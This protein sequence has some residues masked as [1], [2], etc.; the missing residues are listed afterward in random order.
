MFKIRATLLTFNMVPTRSE[1][2]NSTAVEMDWNR[3]QKRTFLDRLRGKN[4]DGD[5]D[6]ETND[7]QDTVG[8]SI[9]KFRNFMSRKQDAKR[10]TQKAEE[11]RVEFFVTEGVERQIE[12]GENLLEIVFPDM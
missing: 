6:D 10:A 12:L 11:S 2:A 9:Q 5:S 4:N 7:E 3:L 8:S 1:W